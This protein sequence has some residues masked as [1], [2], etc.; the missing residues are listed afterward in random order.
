MSD[1]P[2]RIKGDVVVAAPAD[3]RRLSTA[4]LLEQED[5]FEKEI[6]FLRRW[7]R[8]G[9]RAIDIG[10]NIGVYTLTLAKRVGREGAV[11]AFE[12]TPEPAASLRNGIARNGF[13]QVTVVE[14]ALSDQEGRATF[15]TSSQ[16][17]LNSLVHRVDAATALAVDV[18]T[19]DRE[20]ER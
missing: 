8:P 17:E 19:L 5:W 7:L 9:M 20:Q 6:D 16:S 4:V 13:K 3:L 1:Y 14:R 12:P 11:W 10:A 2:I 18:S 15:H